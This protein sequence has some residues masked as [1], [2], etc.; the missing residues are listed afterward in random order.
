MRPRFAVGAAAASVL[1][2][3]APSVRATPPFGEAASARS[4]GGM[5]TA[6]TPESVEAGARVLAAGG[7]A[8]DAAIAAAFALAVTYPQA[9]NLAGGGFAVVRTAEGG[10]YALDFR[11]TAPAG[12]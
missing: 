7:G 12:S 3:A 6:A 1:V 5:V 10:L 8:V 4:K 2:L 11:E 9:G